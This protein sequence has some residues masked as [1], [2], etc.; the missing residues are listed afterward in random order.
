MM[1]LRFLP[2]FILYFISFLSNAIVAK[3][4]KNN[5]EAIRSTKRNTL[6]LNVHDNRRPRDDH[7]IDNAK[8][9]EAVRN[10]VK[11]S[12]EQGGY[13]H[14]YVEIRRWDPSD[15]SSYFGA[16]VN[17]PVKKD[18][19][20]IKI[21]GSI[22]IQIDDFFRMGKLP[23]SD[24]VCE[25]AWTLKREYELGEDS[26]FA[27]YIEYIKT[28]SKYQIPAMWTD[29]GKSL[30]TK[31]Q[32]DLS[33]M[34]FD[35]EDTPGEH[36][37]NWIYEYFGGELCLLDAD[38]EEEMEEWYVAMA[39]QRGYD[40][41]LIPIYDMLNHS[42]ERVNSITRPSIYNR[43]G[44]GVYALED[45]NAGDEILYSYY[46]CPDCKGCPTCG[47]S[48]EYWGTPEMIRD[49]GFVEPYPHR[50]YY[51]DMGPVYLRVD[52]HPDGLE[53]SNEGG[54]WP[55]I[56][57]IESQIAR[58]KPMFERDIYPLRNVLPS[59][60]LETIVNYHGS[61]LDFFTA[62]QEVDAADSKDENHGESDTGRDEDLSDGGEGDAPHC[63]SR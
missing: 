37:H 30:I 22:E 18:E 26:K 21:P 39:T 50:F 13:I 51:D 19:L 2:L 62:Y 7:V 1:S 14:P 54:E 52:E 8:Q 63:R 24:V 61:L 44:F 17:G 55:E 15:P 33:M 28:Q 4:D 9:D 6:N 47:T 32:G 5:A 42:N 27:P 16:F 23:Y 60:E 56:E 12:I 58:L 59:H 53:I 36:M 43:D 3:E 31:V 35:L 49:F 57:W 38:N 20:L 10:M 34:D 25:L 11:W 48:L 41:C 29:V 40:Y 45:L 46:D